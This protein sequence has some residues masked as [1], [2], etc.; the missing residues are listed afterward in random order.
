MSES[1]AK[2]LFLALLFRAA[3][4][5]GD[6]TT[7]GWTWGVNC[8]G[9]G[10]FG[11][12]NFTATNSG[13]FSGSGTCARTSTY[14]TQFVFTS[15]SGGTTNSSTLYAL[16]TGDVLI[17]PPTLGSEAEPIFMAAPNCPVANQTLNWI[18]VQW[19]SSA[20][21][22]QNTY[23]LG[24][25]TYNTSSGI[26]V[27]SQYDVTGAAYWLGTVAMSGSCSGGIYTS[28]GG[29][30]E[31]DGT[32]YFTATGAG[33][34]K[35]NPG[36]ATMFFPQYLVY[37]STDLGNQTAPGISFDSTTATHTKQVV[38]TTS[39]AGTVYTVQPFLNPS[40]GTIDP[41]YTDTITIS[42]VNNP[43]NGMLIGTVTR[44]GSGAGTGKI[45]CIV[46]KDFDFRVFC[47]G[48]SPSNTQYPYNTTFVIQ[49]NCP[50]NYVRVPKNPTVSSDEDFCVAKYE[51]A[52]N[53]SNSAISSQTSNSW[54]SITRDQSITAC[55]AIGAG[56]DLITNAEWQ[57]VARDIES[58]YSGGS[59]LNWSNGL[60]TGSNYLNI[61]NAGSYSGLVPAADSSPCS[62]M[63]AY[64]NCAN[65]TSSDWEFKRTHQLSNGGIVWDLGANYYTWVKDTNTANQGSAG[66]AS[67][68]PWNSG[69]Q[70]KWG[71]A[72]NYSSKNSGT[73]GGLGY[74]YLN[75]SLGAI[76]RGGVAGAGG[77]GSYGGV[78][79]A[80]FLP[81]STSS[82]QV[83][84]RC[85][86]HPPAPNATSP[87]TSSL[88]SSGVTL[89]WNSS[90][91]TTDGFQI[92]YT[93]GSTPPANCYSGTVISE[94]T[95]GDVSSY[96]VSGLAASTQYSFLLCSQS[97]A[98]GLSSG[99][100]ITLTTPPPDVTGIAATVNS[101]TQITVSWTSG[102]GT[103]TGFQMSYQAG[104]TAPA[105]SVP[106][107]LASP[108]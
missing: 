27:T 4:A 15:S 38:V 29:S 19:D 97:E 103:T 77:G 40:A 10:T 14:F 3:L 75:S 102:G 34:Y 56:Y 24:T 57:T 36:H 68:A 54:T 86:W 87:T 65:N 85:T 92:V 13:G 66:F 108:S 20:N 52:N 83:G 50:A 16:H 76:T 74:Q 101:P 104:A 98:G 90:G 1:F 67:Q 61:G 26:A 47:T 62:G 100:S 64:P 84:F 35:T 71:P 11:S 9:E 31:L 91:G 53:G 70:T 46:N 59:Y 106:Q 43:Q 18:F 88:T 60:N 30:S 22:L 80:A 25:A 5:F 2:F 6:T 79:A 93:T 7:E 17:V 73:Y 55:E 72:E 107:A 51:M 12:A 63:A 21:P 81:T 42:S 78:F 48:Q 44:T 89:S 33:V 69:T 37:P 94:S 41:S 82:S 95:I 96:A 45:A 8:D 32:V 49:T 23:L 105:D 28:S 58:A 99:V 39:A